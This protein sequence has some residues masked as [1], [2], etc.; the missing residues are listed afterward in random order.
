MI[1]RKKKGWCVYIISSLRRGRK[2]IKSVGMNMIYEVFHTHPRSFIVVTLSCPLLYKS[3]HTRPYLKPLKN[4]HKS[5]QEKTHTLNCVD[6]IVPFQVK[7]RE[8]S[9]F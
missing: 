2:R 6:G 1:R 9:H 4:L 5:I 7:Q 8:L 3:P